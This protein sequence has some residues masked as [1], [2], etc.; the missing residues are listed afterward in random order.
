MKVHE[1]SK[2]RLWESDA[3]HR[4][5]WWQT[6]IHSPVTVIFLVLLWVPGLLTGTV[7]TGLR[8][9][10]R[11]AMVVTPS[12][13]PGQWW[14]LA[15]GAFWERGLGGY[16]IGTVVLLLVGVP[17]ERRLG[18]VHFAVAGLTTQVMGILVAIG[19]VYAGR[20]LMGS[21]SAELLT[22]AFL[23]PSALVCGAALAATAT[24]GTLWRR[25]LRLTMFAVLIL[26]AFYSGSFP[27]LIRL[28]AATIGVVIGPLLLGRAP[29]VGVPV[30]SR[31]EARVL[32]ALIM[33]TSAIGPVLAGLLPHAV[34]PWPCCGT[35]SPTSRPWIRKPCKHCVPTP[36]KPGTALQPRCN[37]VPVL[38]AFSCQSFR[39]CCC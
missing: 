34:G 2:D 21:W 8:G 10:L 28:A 3:G 36:P 14:T 15:T 9:P 23:G 19:I 27:D 38:A 7:L 11:S 18:S 20:N 35:F 39:R 24:L 13:L 5:A 32:I 6:W 31:R 30:T 22:H 33:A 29:R 26:L 1:Q 17:A 37:C 25:R 4:T 12:S 16:L